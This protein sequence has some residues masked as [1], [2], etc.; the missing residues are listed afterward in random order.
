MSNAISG[1]I[2]MASPPV[3]ATIGHQKPKG[4]ICP[5]KQTAYIKALLAAFNEK[6][7]TAS[8]TMINSTEVSIH[9]NA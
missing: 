2:H 4:R 3:M 9:S 6:T 7:I 1:N 5:R 8:K